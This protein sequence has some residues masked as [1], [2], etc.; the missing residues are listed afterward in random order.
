MAKVTIRKS[1]IDGF[2]SGVAGE[3]RINIDRSGN[4][5]PRSIE[6]VLLGLGA[7]TIS[8]VAHYMGRKGLSQENLAVELSADFDEKGSLYRNL[9]VI[10]RVDDQIPQEIRKVLVGVAKTCRIHR[11]LASSPHVA[12]ELAEPTADE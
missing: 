6:L 7:C 8:T 4:N 12:I 2:Y 9:A 10:L 3:F 5:S 11:T 1:D